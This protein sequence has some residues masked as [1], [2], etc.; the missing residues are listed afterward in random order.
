MKHMKKYILTIVLSFITLNTFSEYVVDQETI[1]VDLNGVS[2]A[3]TTAGNQEDP[4]VLMI[5]GLMASH[6]VWGEEIVNSLVNSGYRVILFDNRD[7]GDSEKLDR[8]GKPNLYWK[9]FLNSIGFNFSAPYTLL[10]MADDG[11]A[12]LDHLQVDQAHIVGASM[13]GMIAQII[14]SNYPEKTNSLVSIMSSTGAPHLSQ[15][16][17]SNEENFR[18]VEDIDVAGAEAY[19]FFPD[20]MPRQLTAIFKAGDR[21]NI[22]MGITIPTLVQHGENDTLL[23]VDHGEHTA[24]LIKGSQFKVYKDMGHNLP[25]EVLPLVIKDMVRFFKDNE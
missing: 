12:L 5:M 23:P 4:A 13:G 19:G 25:P 10:D 24:E 2:I 9:F 16:S 1:S 8:L 14:A 22:V 17:D 6:K 20:A 18:N 7:T 11:V 15:M 21:S 3:Y